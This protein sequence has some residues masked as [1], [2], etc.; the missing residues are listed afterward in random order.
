MKPI[1]QRTAAPTLP[2]AKAA[3]SPQGPKTAPLASRKATSR[4]HVTFS[5]AYQQMSGAKPAASSQKATTQA[6][7]KARDLSRVAEANAFQKL[8]DD[9]RR[10]LQAIMSVTIAKPAPTPAQ[11]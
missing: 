9:A 11:K 1:S 4:D 3:A 7:E 6:R 10:K 5:A 2:L 8:V